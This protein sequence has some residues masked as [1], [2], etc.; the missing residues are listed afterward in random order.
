MRKRDQMS[1]EDNEKRAQRIVYLRDKQHLKNGT[2]QLLWK[3]IGERFGLRGERVTI[4][5]RKEKA[6][7]KEEENAK[8]K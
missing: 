7:L 4:I 5:Y 2:D 1:E 6:R 8:K 3:E